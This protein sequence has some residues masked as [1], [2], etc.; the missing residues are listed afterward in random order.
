MAYCFNCFCQLAEE[1]GPCPHCGFDPAKD[2]G[3]YPFA[4][5]H[6]SILAGRYITGRVLGQ[7]GFG[8][9]YLALDN[10][11]KAKVAIKEFMPDS[12]AVRTT[13][14]PQITV[15]SG[16]RQ[17][18][19]QYGMERFLDE[20]KVL[21]KFQENPHIVGVRSYFEENGTA[22]FVM[23]YVE[24]VSFKSYIQEHGGK[25]SWEEAVRL[26]MPV[27]DALDAV[28]KEGIIHRDVTPDNIFITNDG[29]VKLLDFG[30]ARYSLGDKSRS[31]DVVLK[32]GYAPKEQYTR[33]GRQGPYTDVYSLSACLYSA[34]TGYLPPESLDRADEDDLVLPSTRGI[35]IPQA[36]EDVILHGL[37][38]QPADRYQSMGE[39]RASLDAAVHENAAI[40]EDPSP[41]PPLSAPEVLTP[42]HATNENPPLEPSADPPAISPETDT[43]SPTPVQR[44][45][46]PG[47]YGL[48][49]A[50]G[51]ILL[52]ICLMVYLT[53]GKSTPTAPDTPQTQDENLPAVADSLSEADEFSNQHPSEAMIVVVPSDSGI[54][55]LEDLF[56]KLI[57]ISDM[58]AH[59]P[60][61]YTDSIPDA[62]S[63]YGEGNLLN[64]GEDDL[65]AYSY[66]ISGMADALIINCGSV[67]GLCFDA[68]GSMVPE[69]RILDTE[70]TLES[71]DAGKLEETGPVPKPVSEPVPEPGPDSE[72]GTKPAEGSVKKDSEPLH[73]VTNQEYSI[74]VSYLTKTS[75]KPMRET[76]VETNSLGGEMNIAV[77]TY[78]LAATQSR[79]IM[80]NARIAELKASI[81]D[82][83]QNLALLESEHKYIQQELD[84]LREGTSKTQKLQGSY[85]GEWNE[86][87]PNGKGTFTV[88]TKS[89]YK[90]VWE[91]TWKNGTMTHGTCQYSNGNRYEG[92][93]SGGSPSGYGVMTY[94][95]GDRYEG[96]WQGG[97]KQG[98]GTMKYVGGETVTASWNHDSTAAEIESCE[99]ELQRV[100]RLQTQL[101]LKKNEMETEMR[102]LEQEGE[103]NDLI[104]SDNIE[105]SFKYFE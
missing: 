18:N 35:K 41:E 84:Y 32:A 96:N 15:Y 50:G 21:A 61:A 80:R 23:E 58:S 5:P 59:Y 27:M 85:T 33:R 75:A 17:E 14:T 88:S 53:A 76:A 89:A 7:G 49:A 19:F 94:Q 47:K 26:L 34:I 56:G 43:E 81:G 2:Q 100:E 3:K 83:E 30:S 1:S 48:I 79:I 40:Q 28:H 6:G 101:E 16:Q 77:D 12:M 65:T 99:K 95:N 20:A 97:M 60:G 55:G 63:L 68:D 36:V 92:N 91:G 87:K 82:V 4:L 38:V 52:L 90:G 57:A 103:S 86:G 51:C 22:Y 69:V 98:D 70:W 74:T 10:Q 8:I 62:I 93:L 105:G 29:G 67:R 42:T 64:A 45:G 72:Q 104:I 102:K 46:K 37:E 39:L 9:T 44:M 73:Y 78:G 11:Q 24:G 25:V 66:L 54:N 71:A 31:L 13:G